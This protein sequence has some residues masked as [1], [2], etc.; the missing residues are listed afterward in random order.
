MESCKVGYS[1]IIGGKRKTVASPGRAG[2]FA[3]ALEQWYRRH[4]RDLPWRRT[5]D[6]YAIWV[7][8]IMLQQ[9]RVETVIPYYKRFL[10]RFPDI[11]TLAAAPEQELL[12][13]WAGLGYYSR[14][15]N[16]RRAAQAMVDGGG[17]PRDY[18]AIRALPGIGDYTAAAVASIA[19]G[20]PYAVLDGNVMRVMARVSDDPGDI[21]SSKTRRR[22]L[23][24]ATARLDPADPG[25]FNQAV[26]ELGASL[27]APVNPKC[28]LCPVASFCEARREG[29][30]RELPVKSRPGERRTASVTLL[31]IQKD[32]RMLLWQRGPGSR[33]L[34]GFWE[35][36]EPHMLAAAEVIETVG[37]FRH[38]ITDTSYTITVKRASVHRK[39]RGFEWAIPDFLPLSTTAR[40][41]LRLLNRPR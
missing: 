9:T 29:R 38:G 26:M 4:R 2:S 39:P 14:V 12:T 17:F 1:S 6:P 41:A 25:L 3:Q 13:H 33:R 11:H 37:Q 27:C 28:M 10:A 23:D 36:P 16:M 34:S 18:D 31:A 5:T 22:L 21:R 24:G 7:S 35:L 32:S 20:L 30:E 40:K 15:R 8:E 19:F